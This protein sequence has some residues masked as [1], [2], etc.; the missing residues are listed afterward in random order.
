MWLTFYSFRRSD[1]FAVFTAVVDYYEG[2]ILKFVLVRFCHGNNLY[3]GIGW[4]GR[5]LF[6]LKQKLEI[7]QHIDTLLL[8]MII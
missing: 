2:V 4:R 6:I 5:R 7:T 8:L 3:G 1:I